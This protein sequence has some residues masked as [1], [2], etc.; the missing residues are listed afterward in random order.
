MRAALVTYALDVGGMESFLLMLAEGLRAEGV[1]V[2]FVVTEKIGKWH[3]RPKELGFD[4]ITVCPS[5]WHSRRWQARRLTSVLKSYDAVVLNYCTVAHAILGELLPSTLVISILHNHAEGIYDTGLSNLAN[6]DYVVCVGSKVYSETL[7]RGATERQAVIIP[8]GVD[9]PARWPKEQEGSPN[10]RPLKLIYVGRI[11]HYQ[12]GVLDIPQIIAEA[13]RRGA[14]MELDVVGDGEP[15]LSELR[16]QFA[17]QLPGFGVRFHG[18]LESAATHRLLAEADVLLMPS[19]FEGLPVTLLEAIARGTVPIASLLP[20]ITD[21]AVKNGETGIL[22]PVGDVPAFAEAIVR[23]QNDET[24][25]RM[26]LAAWQSA[27]RFTKDRMVVQYLQLLGKPV[28]RTP[29]PDVSAEIGRRFY[30]RA[31]ELP[32][33]LVEF[34]RRHRAAA[35]DGSP[36]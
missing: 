31:W 13:T 32:I 35:K 15:D 24:R 22:L 10:G 3:G 27:S 36:S 25:R 12:K 21:D 34:V 11:D 17:A 9:V 30:S 14:N 5:Q 2:S 4:T 28:R 6:I 26:S 1:D 20:G 19:R 33:G 29:A 7:G 18:R 23:L 8:Y 16:K